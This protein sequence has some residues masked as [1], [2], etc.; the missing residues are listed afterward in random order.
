MW[1]TAFSYVGFGQK[2]QSGNDAHKPDIRKL[3]GHP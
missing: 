3:T 2:K 1:K